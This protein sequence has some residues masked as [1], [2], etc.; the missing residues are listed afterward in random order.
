MAVTRSMVYLEGLLRWGD[1]KMALKR[2]VLDTCDH[3][4]FIPTPKYPF[5]PLYTYPPVLYSTRTRS[6]SKAGQAVYVSFLESQ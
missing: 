1:N 6:R 4:D 2:A 3:P 5:K